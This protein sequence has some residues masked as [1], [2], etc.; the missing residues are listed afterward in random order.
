VDF[1]ASKCKN[2]RFAS[3]QATAL[4]LF[5]LVEFDKVFSKPLP[6][7]GKVELVV[8]GVVMQTLNLVPPPQAAAAST[9]TT[10]QG[11]MVWNECASP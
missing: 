8:D 7:E 4:S 5:A 9:S 11:G 3:T 10:C 2:G 1:I 6:L